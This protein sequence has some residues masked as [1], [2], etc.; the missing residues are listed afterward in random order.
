MQ[1]RPDISRWERLQK[2]YFSISALHDIFKT[3]FRFYQP[4]LFFITLL[5]IETETIVF[6]GLVQSLSIPRV[7]VGVQDEL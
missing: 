7:K 1:I 4:P 5:P 3:P 2:L 6:N